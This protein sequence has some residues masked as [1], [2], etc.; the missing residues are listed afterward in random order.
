VVAQVRC[1][2][3]NEC[4]RESN[5]RLCAQFYRTVSFSNARAFFE[6]FCVDVF[7]KP[8]FFSQ[9]FKVRDYFLFCFFTQFLPV[10]IAKKTI[11]PVQRIH[12]SEICRCL[13]K[14]YNHNVLFADLV[15]V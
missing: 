14:E 10:F 5:S 6:Q 1:Q 8:Y 15:F 4:A 7:V 9:T 2:L 11:T 3:Q 13:I 12:P